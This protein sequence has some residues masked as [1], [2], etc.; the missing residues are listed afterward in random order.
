VGDQRPPSPGNNA[1]LADT[2]LLEELFGFEVLPGR[3]LGSAETEVHDPVEVHEPG[4][5][6]TLVTVV[7]QGLELSAELSASAGRSRCSS[8]KKRTAAL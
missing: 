5:G 4:P 3:R 8:T 1:R 2:Q 7:E 6:N